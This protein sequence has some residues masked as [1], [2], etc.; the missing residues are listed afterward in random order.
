MNCLMYII[1]AASQAWAELACELIDWHHA[2]T[3]LPRQANPLHRYFPPQSTHYMQ[4]FPK[5]PAHV[6]MSPYKHLN[7]SSKDIPFGFILG[8]CTQWCSGLISHSVHGLPVYNLGTCNP[9]L[10][11]FSYVAQPCTASTC[12]GDHSCRAWVYVANLHGVSNTLRH[13]RPK[14]EWGRAYPMLRKGRVWGLGRVS[15][16]GEWAGWKPAQLWGSS[17]IPTASALSFCND[18]QPWRLGVDRTSLREWGG[19]ELNRQDED[20]ADCRSGR[21]QMS[22][23]VRNTS[24][25]RKRVSQYSEFVRWGSWWP[26]CQG[27]EPTMVAV[28]AVNQDHNQKEDG[29]G[30]WMLRHPRSHI[31]RGTWGSRT[32]AGGGKLDSYWIWGE[33]REAKGNVTPKIHGPFSKRAKWGKWG[34]KGAQV[35][36]ARVSLSL[37]V[38]PKMRDRQGMSSL[39]SSP[40]TP[41]SWPSAVSI[42]P[43]SQP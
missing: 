17:Q 26:H 16:L 39:S 22:R 41:T 23:K 21:G 43:G 24:S 1:S 40:H 4:T 9:S 31:M 6:A 2:I 18:D 32:R 42:L 36:G 5:N 38:S 14:R 35:P 33:I 10:N 30:K 12:T 27:P 20:S 19:W 11:S 3:V 37:W 25:G 15:Y 29:W 28:A 7:P 34:Q 8:G 13:A